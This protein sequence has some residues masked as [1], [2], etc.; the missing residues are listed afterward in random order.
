M[1]RPALEGG[2]LEAIMGEELTQEQREALA[3][4]K[5]RQGRYWK[6]RLIALWAAGRDDQAPDGALLRQVRN[7]LGLDGLARVKI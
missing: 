7:S 4:F 6:S 2:K 1:N 3:R 5:D